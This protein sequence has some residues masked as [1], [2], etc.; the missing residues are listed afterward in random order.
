M[1]TVTFDPSIHQAIPTIQLGLLEATR[2]TNRPYDPALW[3]ML[4]ELEEHVRRK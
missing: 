3:T 2:A 4:T 1:I